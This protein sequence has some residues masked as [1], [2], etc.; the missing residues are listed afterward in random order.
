MDKAFNTHCMFMREY[1]IKHP[2]ELE[3]LFVYIQARKQKDLWYR[4]YI[5]KYIESF[6]YF[7]CEYQ[8]TNKTSKKVS[9]Q[10]EMFLI[11]QNSKDEIMKKE[12]YQHFTLT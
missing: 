9:L 5:K 12:N 11:D 10:N 4:I 8:N 6:Q 2:K 3:G 1:A 7:D